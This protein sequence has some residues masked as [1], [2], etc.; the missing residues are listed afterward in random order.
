MPGSFSRRRTTIQPRYN[1]ESARAKREAHIGSLESRSNGAF[2]LYV[3]DL[4]MQTY[5][6]SPVGMKTGFLARSAEVG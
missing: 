4:Q 2:E 1:W 3:D 5:W 6:L